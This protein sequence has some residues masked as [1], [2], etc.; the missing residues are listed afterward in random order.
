MARY[1]CNHVE[2][3]DHDVAMTVAGGG[4]GPISADFQPH[5]VFQY[6]QGAPFCVTQ[7]APDDRRQPRLPATVS[8]FALFLCRNGVHLLCPWVT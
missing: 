3:F 1:F 6:D 4:E 2:I 8:I 7:G 5:L